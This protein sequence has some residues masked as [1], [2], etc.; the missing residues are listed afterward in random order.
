MLVAGD[1]GFQSLVLAVCLV[2]P[3][4]GLF[5]RHKWQLGMA[6]KDEINRLLVFASEE[7]ARVE[8][9][10]SFGHI[11]A[12]ISLNHHCALCFSPTTTRCARCKAVRYC[13]G[14]CQIIHWRQGHKNECHPPKKLDWSSE[15][16][17]DPKD[18]LGNQNHSGSYD[19]NFDTDI[20]Q[21]VEPDKSLFAKHASADSGYSSGVPSQNDISVKLHADEEENST[22]KLPDTTSYEFHT[23][24]LDIESSDDASVSENNSESGSP[25][26]DGYLS[27]ENSFDM[28]SAT[29]RVLNVDHDPNK[30]LSSNNAHL[31]N[32]VDIYAKLKTE[33]QLV[34]NWIGPEY[35]IPS[36]AAK[37]RNVPGSGEAA[38][39]NFQ[40]NNG[41]SV[42]AKGDVHEDS[43]QSNSNGAKNRNFSEG[44]SLLH[45]SFSVSGVTSQS[46][47]QFA[48][49]NEHVADGNLPT[50]S[51]MN[52]T[53]ESSLLLDIN[54]ESLKVRSSPSSCK[55]SQD[56]VNT[57]KGLPD[58]C[59][60]NSV[61]SSSSFI[62][63][64]PVASKFG[65]R[66]IR[67]SN[68]SISV[69]VMSERLGSVFIEPGTTS[70]I[71]EHSGNGSLVDGSSVHLPPSNGREPVP[72]TDSRKIGT[73][74]VSAGVSSLDAN[75]SSK[76]AYG[77]RP[78]APNEL[79]RSKSHRGYVANG[80]GNAGKCNNKGDSPYELFVNLYNWNKVELQPSGLVNC[81]NS[82]YANVVLQ[83][84]TFT[85]PLTAYFLQG[86]H[87]KACAKEKWCF[88]CE[89]ESLILEAK[90]G[91][92]PLS[93]FRIISQLRKI[94]SQLVNGKEEDAH[95]F[96]RC[97]IDT[98]QS[99]CPMEAQASRTGPVEEETTLIGLTFGGYLL[100]KIKCTRCE[101][102]SER[103]ERI[104]DLTVEISGDI[105]TIEE[106]LQQYTSP[107][108]LDGDNRYHCT[109]CNSYVKARKR[110]SILE[111]PN[112]LTI[113]LKRFQ[114][115]KF[116]KLNKP[117]IFSEI[118][119]LAPY[120]SSRSDKSPV[121]RLYGVIV[122]L[123]VMNAAFSGHYVCYIRNNQNKWFK[124]DDST[125]TAMDVK[126]VLTR[127]AYMLFYARCSP[128]AP[129]LIRN[130]ITTDSRNRCIPSL[131]NG[132]SSS[133]KSSSNSTYPDSQNQHMNNN[134]SNDPSNISSFYR[135][136]HQLKKLLEEDLTSDSSSLFSSHSDE[137]SCGTN[138]SSDS[139]STDDLPEYFYSSDSGCGWNG[140]Q[141]PSD[142][143]ASL[144]SSSSSSPLLHPGD[145]RQC[146]AGG[147]KTTEQPQPNYT[148]GISNLSSRRECNGREKTAC[149]MEGK[150]GVWLHS[151]PSRQC[152][153]VM[154]N[155]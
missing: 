75:F 143:D 151:D 47:A 59:V 86:L 58:D 48:E 77:F 12:P 147:A 70:S 140:L 11:P 136:F 105:E 40:E 42:G 34:F 120:M 31:V 72:P 52:R 61:S 38:S 4:I 137:S 117:V 25:R 1:L 113:A 84:L 9:Q 41:K 132:T 122:H 150:D 98:M 100:S 24:T 146:G 152:S 50:T 128:R 130:K 37:V 112:I 79:R 116:G 46:N 91:K 29:S 54:T 65:S 18:N 13:S 44:H 103:I 43:V 30:P 39:S 35:D 74:Q 16:E 138:S 3:I 114:S 14:R 134:S 83:C 149:L 63:P 106:A 33:S 62:N 57:T 7:A 142:V 148:N 27:A 66:S 21:H 20:G 101:N 10:A 36:K 73:T 108:I 49:V 89:F 56:K 155:G 121:Y 123:D 19:K 5:L 129:R 111:A 119:D 2:F 154:S 8:L 85:P 139:T 23:S 26:S 126:N 133:S 6:R 64:F 80:A 110:L 60:V 104:L 93:P 124:V 32:S 94:G 118:L 145:S 107:E 45:F 55:G 17:N 96:L 90:E 67:D 68:I 115:G 87:S 69:P 95:E 71:T 88:T 81:G 153:N 51:G 76:S 22:P 78:F 144:P 99:I 97:A 15:K 135:K 109:R 127:G 28:D 92:S 53:V 141:T 125:V 82:C 131:I 102:K